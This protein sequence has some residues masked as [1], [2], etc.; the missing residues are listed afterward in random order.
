MIRC[1][2]HK[3]ETVS[4]IYQRGRF[5]FVTCTNVHKNRFSLW[6]VKHI[7]KFLTLKTLYFAAE[8]E[9]KLSGVSMAV[10]NVKALLS[11]AVRRITRLVASALQASWRYKWRLGVGY[12]NWECLITTRASKE[13]IK[14]NCYWCIRKAV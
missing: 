1:F 7:I 4:F 3:A 5:I 10:S 8:S 13:C 9:T 14:L 6:K 2:Y 11:L 12:W